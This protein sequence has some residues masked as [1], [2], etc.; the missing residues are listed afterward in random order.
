LSLAYTFFAL[1]DGIFQEDEK[2]IKDLQQ[3]ISEFT[4]TAIPPP[5]NPLDDI[6]PVHITD[7]TG[8]YRVLMPDE[9]LPEAWS[10]E[11]QA[12]ISSQIALFRGR[13]VERKQQEQ[14]EENRWKKD[15]ER[16]NETT[17]NRM[18]GFIANRNA[19]EEKNS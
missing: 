1:I 10:G 16:R 15:L 19:R 5:E 17:T 18:S 13:E 14:A 4:S 9:P 12:T 2:R 7:E 11:R 8:K 6:K 3:K